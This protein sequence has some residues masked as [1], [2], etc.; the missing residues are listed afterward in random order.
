[1]RVVES[2]EETSVWCSAYRSAGLSVGLV[3]TMGA[4]H[5]GHLA[6]VR[7]ASSE[8]DR[9]VVS[10][11]VNPTQFG[12]G[13]DL[14]AYPRTLEADLEACRVVG[15]GLVFVAREHDIYPSGFQTWVNVTE[16]T[17]P[18]CGRSRPVHFRGVATVVAQLLHL[19]EPH[20]VYFGQK[21]YQQARVIERLVLD[22]HFSSA[23]CI[24]PTVR[25]ADGLALSSRNE[26]LS[27]EARCHAVVLH[28]S[29]E[30][31]EQEIL[32]GERRVSLV[33]EVL[34]DCLAS[35]PGIRVD[36]AEV[37]RAESLTSPP[38]GALRPGERLVL[39][40]AAYF[41]ETRLIDNRL[42]VVGDS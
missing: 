31:A 37:L 22:L 1:M 35:A 12:P 25:E 9:V 4:L 36:Y 28:R 42:L 38:D 27:P 5:H 13:E 29:L 26:Y 39:A 8:C 21:D 24:V 7:Q 6:L 40:V 30:R 10:I 18:L 19:V 34:H 33:R 11:F 14:S 41:D 23:V 16:L 2:G 32:K 17:A 15:V 20:R 3:P